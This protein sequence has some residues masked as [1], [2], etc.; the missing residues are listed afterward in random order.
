MAELTIRG[1]RPADMPALVDLINLADQADR[2]G[3]YTTQEEFSDE[4]N[5]S[6]ESPERVVWL[7]YKDDE[8]CGYVRLLVRADEKSRQFV[9]LGIV[10]PH[11]RRQGIGRLLMDHALAAAESLKGAGTNQFR[12][13]ARQ[14]VLGINELA[15]S[16]GLQ[17]V[18]EFSL[19][20][21]DDLSRLNPPLCP[22][23]YRIRTYRVG[24]DEPHWVA[25]HNESFAD[26]ADFVA[27]RLDDEWR[28]SHSP[29]FVPEDN[30]L[31]VEQNAGRIVGFC[32]LLRD[33][34]SPEQ[35]LVDFLAI[36]PGCRGRGLGTIL[37]QAGLQCLREAGCL[38]ARLAVSD[39]NKYGARSLYERVGFAPWRK[40]VVYARDMG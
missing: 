14:S 28:Y 38:E 20:R 9:C 12:L 10:H 34:G 18:E 2:A 39:A 33:A 3:L 26:S 29:L 23:G 36:V 31:L 6:I 40:T 8:L 5:A 19:L 11:Y 32:R 37:L 4:L 16:A 15:L 24:D 27:W 25:V 17:P 35:G 1:Y 13:P 22:S 30:L 7:V 21:Y